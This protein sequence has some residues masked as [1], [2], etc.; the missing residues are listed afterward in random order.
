[1]SPGYCRGPQAADGFASDDLGPPPP[2]CLPRQ[3]PG[4]PGF[5]CWLGHYVTAQANN[6]RQVVGGPPPRLA[7]IRHVPRTLSVAHGVGL[8]CR[9]VGKPC[10][11]RPCAFFFEIFARLRAFGRGAE[12]WKRR[13]SSSQHLRVEP[14]PAPPRTGA[15]QL[16]SRARRKLPRG[17][18]D[19]RN[20]HC[21]E[22]RMKPG[23]LCPT[24]FE[25]CRKNWPRGPSRPDGRMSE[26]FLRPP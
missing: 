21:S 8:A 20:L 2:S 26:A 11:A 23:E 19:G 15:P 14:R 22:H 12:E 18:Q 17:G 13:S 24:D 16:A 7:Y 25:R 4:P 3:K 6:L 5:C 1:M 9:A 10:V